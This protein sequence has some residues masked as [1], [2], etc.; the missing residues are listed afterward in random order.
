MKFHYVEFKEVSEGEC[1]SF[2]N[3]FFKKVKNN[4]VDL[5]GYNAIFMD[6]PLEGNFLFLWQNTPVS[7]K[8][9]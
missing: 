4:F 8:I 6:G 9:K 7:V 3:S 1:F 5:D 2:R